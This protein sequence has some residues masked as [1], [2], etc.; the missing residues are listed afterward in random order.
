MQEGSVMLMKKIARGTC[1]NVNYVSGL[2]QP[3][4]VLP[5][6]GKVKSEDCLSKS[7]RVGSYVSLPQYRVFS[8]YSAVTL[9][10]HK[11]DHH[12]NLP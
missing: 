12:T 9:L 1:R 7:Q 11:I 3:Q 2:F 4:N 6:D 10:Y 5:K 8:E